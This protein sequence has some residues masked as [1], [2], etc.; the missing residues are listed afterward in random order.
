MESARKHVPAPPPAHTS[1]AHT[2][3]P[4]LDEAVR[5]PA[6]GRKR[7]PFLVLGGIAAAVVLGLGAYS[8]ITSGK[9]STD[10]AQVEAD[11][12][13]IASRVPGM[14]KRIPVAENQRVKK[15]DLL[16]EL[17][18]ADILAREQ[19]AEAELETAQAQAAAAD[20]QAAVAAA[21]A[22]GGFSTAQAQVT[23][24]SAGMSTARAQ[25]EAARAG[26]QRAEADAR[27]AAL[28]LQRD[29]KLL[30][31]SVIP[32]AR[33]DDSQAEND[34]KQAALSQARANLTAAEEAL[35]A[36]ESRVGEARGRF[37]QSAQVKPQIAAAEAQA[38]LAHAREK[39]AEAA[40]RLARLQLS[41]TKISA[42]DDGV[43]SRLAVHEGQL[44]QVG[45][46]IA[47]L[48]PERTYV[49]AN[50]KE[51]QIGRMRAGEAVEVKIDA[52]PG[53]TLHGQVESLSGGTGARF[54]LL[55]PDNASGNF[56]KVVQRVPVRIAWVDPPADL[57]LRAGL[58]A[59]VTV[60]V[61]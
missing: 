55:P 37:E 44:V 1:P 31:A 58:S 49:V 54:S 7:K 42:E 41:Y 56:V 38:R 45:Q 53:R 10:D 46:P 43:V 15:G 61:K 29:Q 59:D 27:K 23:G 34:V 40:L 4:A 25:V 2:P 52:F 35:R 51:T 28:D 30:A 21:G 6:A 9:E 24:S 20:A 26:L 32:Q 12:V 3:K 16:V 39:S 13:P 36:A 57:P 17:D 18:D 8:W 19:Q 60:R 33:L 48:V 47:A 14:V 5:A 11:V 22:R 50:F